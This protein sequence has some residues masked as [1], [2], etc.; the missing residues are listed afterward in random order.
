MFKQSRDRKK[1]FKKYPGSARVPGNRGISGESILALEFDIF[2]IW[3]FSPRHRLVR[4][5]PLD[6]ECPNMLAQVASNVLAS[7]KHLSTIINSFGNEK[8][9]IGGPYCLI[10]KIDSSVHMDRSLRMVRDIVV[11][12]VISAKSYKMD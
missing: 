8:E 3:Q 11:L 10:F 2:Q 4:A 6:I 9:R 5:S 1:Y 7:T 12:G